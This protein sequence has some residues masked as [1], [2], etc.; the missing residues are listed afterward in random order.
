ML[1][2]ILLKA[3]HTLVARHREIRLELTQM[4]L[5]VLEGAMQTTVGRKVM[6]GISQ[7]CYSTDMLSNACSPV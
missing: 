1:S 5:A 6:N 2:P 7:P 4:A 3:Q